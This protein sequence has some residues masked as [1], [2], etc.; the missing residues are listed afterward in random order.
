MADVSI[1]NLPAFVGT[2][3]GVDLFVMV[4]TADTSE[5][6][7]GTTKRIT[8]GQ[9]GGLP[10]TGTL[11]IT[12]TAT[13]NPGI[14]LNDATPTLQG[15]LSYL[16][17]SAAGARYVSLVNVAGDALYLGTTNPTPIVFAV[18][19]S[20]TWQIT[21][22][23]VFSPTSDATRD[24]GQSGVRIRNLYMSGALTVGPITASGTITTTGA[25]TATGVL[26]GS[27]LNFGALTILQTASES[28]AGNT[29][30][31]TVLADPTGTTS[32]MMGTSAALGIFA[33]QADHYLFLSRNAATEFVDLSSTELR[34]NVRLNVQQYI[35]FGNS[36]TNPAPFAGQ[37]WYDGT[38]LWFQ[39]SGTQHALATG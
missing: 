16:A 6:P 15:S 12:G 22:G 20:L 30:T 7:L 37:L 18:G 5:S 27:H 21:G 28:P 17:T 4:D 3:T 2:P 36:Y 26:T 33:T 31:Y 13:V 11:P 19:G 34:T 14:T 1:A 9:L 8:T 39:G 10:V 38:T 23:G 35:Y 24:I 32:L 29:G 25:V